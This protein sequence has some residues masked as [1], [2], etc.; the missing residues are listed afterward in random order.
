M[1]E[2]YSKST[3]S[4]AKTGGVRNRPVEYE[5]K[6]RVLPRSV[7][8][9]T[10][11]GTQSIGS[12]GARLDSSNNRITLVADDGTVVGFGAIPGSLTNEFGFFSL[13]SD[14]TLIFKIVNGTLYMYDADTGINNLQL[15]KLPDGTTNLAIAKEGEDVTEAF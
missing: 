12:G 6:N 7:S 3:N 14:G 13:D 2:I 9:G 15:G 5:I 10:M 4:F 1:P 8:T 11:R